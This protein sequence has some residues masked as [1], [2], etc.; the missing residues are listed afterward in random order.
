MNAKLQQLPLDERIELVEDL[1][2]SIAADQ[3]ALPL[4][5][6]QRTE[7]DKRLDAYELDKNAGRPPSEVLADIRRRL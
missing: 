4:T 5:P 6:A 7:L 2:D 3:K 1:R